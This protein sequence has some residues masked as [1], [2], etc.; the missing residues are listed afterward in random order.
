MA[1]KALALLVI[2]LVIFPAI[3]PP[4][5]AEA[6]DLKIPRYSETRVFGQFHSPTPLKSLVAPTLR[7]P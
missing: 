6:Q 4:K 2:C 1:T 5:A 3:L 7:N